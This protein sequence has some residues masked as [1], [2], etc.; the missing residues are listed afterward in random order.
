MNSH[1]AIINGAGDEAEL[2]AMDL[3]ATSPIVK[4]C[5]TVGVTE[6]QVRA[7]VDAWFD[8]PYGSTYKHFNAR[9]R[10]AIEAAFRT[11]GDSHE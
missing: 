2:R 6:N 8:H 9:M 1:Q 4:E 5:A 3:L 10:R 7:A 11:Q